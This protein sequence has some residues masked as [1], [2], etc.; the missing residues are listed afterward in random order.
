MIIYNWGGGGEYAYAGRMW[1]GR[2]VTSM[3]IREKTD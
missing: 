2:E 3:I 1:D